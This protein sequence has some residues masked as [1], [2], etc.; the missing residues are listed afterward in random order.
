MSTANPV[1]R[2]TVESLV[3]AA[4]V[5]LAT[6]LGVEFGAD[7]IGPAASAIA[8]LIVAA[9]TLAWSAIT[10]KRNVLTPPPGGGPLLV[11]AL[12]CLAG[13][14][15]IGCQPVGPVRTVGTVQTS[16]DP[17]NASSVVEGSDEFGNATIAWNDSTNGPV[18]TVKQTETEN[19]VRKTGQVT[20]E[21]SFRDGQRTL[22][23]SAGSDLSAEGVTI[24]PASGVL[25]VGRFSTSSSEPIR[26]LN[27][28][29][30]RYQAVWAQLSQEQRA[31]IEAQLDAIKVISPD[32]FD[33][34][35]GLIGLP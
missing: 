6:W 30:D 13:F 10:H 27:E 9:A 28:G 34:L 2:S 1:V 23:I 21:I 7:T 14:G 11:L 29:L 5:A 17:L 26:A 15:M 25:T 12:V 4:L 18:S 31:A 8:V 20:R 3:R 22:L 33:V 16:N 19:L 32:L 35:K 24:D